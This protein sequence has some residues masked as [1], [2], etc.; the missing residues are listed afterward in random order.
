MVE[1]DEGAVE[2]GGAEEVLELRRWC[3]SLARYSSKELPMNFCSYPSFTPFHAPTPAPPR[4]P[5]KQ[6]SPPLYWAP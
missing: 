1:E 3:K 4:A 5:P 2:E 6:S